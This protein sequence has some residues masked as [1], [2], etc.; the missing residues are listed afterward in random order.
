MPEFFVH[1]KNEKISNPQVIRKAFQELQDGRYL[2]KIDKA[3]KRSLPQNAYYHGVIVP[4]VKNGLK[5]IGYNEVRT[6]ED[7]H[8]CLKYLFLKKQIPNENTGEVIEILGSTAKLTTTE[9][10]LFIEQVAQW[11]SEYLGFVL[12]MPNEQ[13][14]I[15]YS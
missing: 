13:M 1:I 8:E 2:V 11:C 6:N 3:N 7:A 10:N 15:S 9:F 4:L 12:P 5:D 14:Q